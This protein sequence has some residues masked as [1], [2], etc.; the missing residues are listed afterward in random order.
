M[1]RIIKGAADT[2]RNRIILDLHRKGLSYNKI[3]R[4]MLRRGFDLTAQR[5]QAIVKSKEAA[6]AAAARGTK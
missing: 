4:E 1:A 6:A 3:S 5:C 2:P